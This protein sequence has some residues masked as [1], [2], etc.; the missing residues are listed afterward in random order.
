MQVFAQFGKMSGRVWSSHSLYFSETTGLAKI[1]MLRTNKPWYFPESSK[2]LH[3]Y[4]F[5]IP[6]RK[7]YFEN[8]I[9]STWETSFMRERAH[10]PVSHAWETA[11]FQKI[12]F[13]RNFVI[14]AWVASLSPLLTFYEA[15]QW[16][17]YI[18][19]ADFQE[20][21]QTVCDFV[22][23]YDTVTISWKIKT[24]IWPAIG[25]NHFQGW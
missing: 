3:D 18:F 4:M 10:T 5:T 25:W 23:N 9:I 24:V 16:F 14:N 1:P 22:W 8:K 15:T 2:N 6:D 13:G 7:M 11:L 17:N 21:N 20:R 12:S 19:A